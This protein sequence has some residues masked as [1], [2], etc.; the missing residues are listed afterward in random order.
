[1]RFESDHF[2]RGASEFGFI[3][4]SLWNILTQFLKKNSGI[5]AEIPRSCLLL[6]VP[7]ECSSIEEALRN[8]G[9]NGNRPSIWALQVFML[10]AFL[11]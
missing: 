8:K 1:M 6:H 4:P 10:P 11:I 3:F 9:F 5:G 7:L 2:L